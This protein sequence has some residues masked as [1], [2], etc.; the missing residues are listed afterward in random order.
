MKRPLN[1]GTA[2]VLLAA[3]SAGP[4]SRQALIEKAKSLP[5]GKMALSRLMRRGN[6]ALEYRR[7]A[8]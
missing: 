5:G 1:S 6:V 8:K 7:V 3:L 2:Q 4:M